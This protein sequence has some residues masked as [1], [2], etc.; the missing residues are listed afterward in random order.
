MSTAHKLVYQPC[1]ECKQ[2]A[3]VYDHEDQQLCT[4]CLYLVSDNSPDGE[5]RVCRK[6]GLRLDDFATTEDYYPLVGVCW[7]C[8]Y[9]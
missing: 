3:V 6:Q 1:D 2:L 4:S 7:E 5:C 8:H 9:N